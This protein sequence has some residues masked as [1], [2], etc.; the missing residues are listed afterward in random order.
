MRIIIL[1]DPLENLFE[2]LAKNRSRRNERERERQFALSMK[3]LRRRSFSRALE[4][5]K[6]ELNP[7]MHRRSF[8]MERILRSM[9]M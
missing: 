1:M 7:R 6:R 3:S 8:M 5:F 9:F 4:C 2:M